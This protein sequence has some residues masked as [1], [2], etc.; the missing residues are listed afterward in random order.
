[1]YFSD[2]NQCHSNRIRH[3]HCYVIVARS[4]DVYNNLSDSVMNLA[5]TIENVNFLD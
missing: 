4:I 3:W 2:T 5:R 1:M